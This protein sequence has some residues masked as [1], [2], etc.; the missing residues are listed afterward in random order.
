MEKLISSRAVYQD[1]IKTVGCWKIIDYRG[2]REQAQ[3]KMSN[4]LVGRR[5]RYLE[6]CGILESTVYDRK[7]K[8]FYLTDLGLK[9][10]KKK[11]N[12][13]PEEETLLH[14]L[15]AG[16][17]VREICRHDR[18]FHADMCHLYAADDIHP[19]ATVWAKRG[20]DE[21]RIAIELELTQKSKERVLEKYGKYVRSKKFDYVV[22]I[23]QKQEL[24]SAYLECLGKL[25]K[26]SREKFVFILNEDLFPGHVDFKDSY[27]LH[28][29]K[30]VEFVEF[31]GPKRAEQYRYK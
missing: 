16:A 11:K 31:F 6:R 19:D 15:L 8:Y 27:C 23:T 2:I 14:D 17:V 24:V 26:A 12:Y 30:K 29:G 20:E 4:T 5:V 9:I 28:L 22:F 7:K 10:A 13:R 21:Y 1:I 18:V 25:N 3:T